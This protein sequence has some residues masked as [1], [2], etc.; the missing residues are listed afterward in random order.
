M[1]SGYGSLNR[2]HV[3]ALQSGLDLLTK[4]RRGELQGSLEPWEC[5]GCPAAG[6]E[7]LAHS[8]E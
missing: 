3:R 6:Q 5:V 7:E 8:Q 4:V 2:P 1:E